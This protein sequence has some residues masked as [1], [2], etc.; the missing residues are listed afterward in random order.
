MSTTD[1]PTDLGINRTGIYLSPI[2]GP[3]VVEGAREGDPSSPGS[4]RELAAVRRQFIDELGP[5]GHMPPPASLRGVVK[6][7]ATVLKGQRANVFLD[8]LGERLAFERTGVR[9]YDGLIAK[10]EAE[11]S[12]HGGPTLPDLVEFRA[13][14]A[15][16]FSLMQDVMINLGADPTALT[17]SADLAGVEAMGIL[18]VI[19]DGRTNLA[20]ALHAHLVA[21][22]TDAAAWDQLISLTELL[23]HE[24]TAAKFR[25][26]LVQEIRH[27]DTVMTWLGRHTALAARGELKFS[28]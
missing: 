18:Q 7:A 23:G 10:L 1:R 8:K 2:D 6:T 3:A 13:D 25:D 27:R 20:Q 28:A 5:I 26:A 22:L 12:W 16:H 15:R 24:A 17:P 4:A 9:L 21:E 14:E 11:G 19:T